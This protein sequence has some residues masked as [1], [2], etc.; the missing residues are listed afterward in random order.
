MLEAMDFSQ[1][2]EVIEAT[3]AEFADEVTEKAYEVH[4]VE[5]DPCNDDTQECYDTSTSIMN[6]AIQGEIDALKESFAQDVWSA[7]LNIEKVVEENHLA[8]RTC[9]MEA[10]CEPEC[11]S[12]SSLIQWTN[13]V[14]LMKEI[15]EKMVTE[16]NKYHDILEKVT[17]FEAECSGY[18]ARPE[19]WDAWMA[20]MEAMDSDFDNITA[21][22]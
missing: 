10:V 17:E 16:I 15:K 2:D 11:N 8:Q 7:I 12:E 3:V 14:T 6:Q 19:G 5:L 13:T 21:A 9:A 18:G 1:T 22:V 4:G 20:E